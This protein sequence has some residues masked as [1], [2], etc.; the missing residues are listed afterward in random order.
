M[1]CIEVLNGYLKHLPTLKNSPKAV[2]TTTKGNNPFSKAD[3]VVAIILASVPIT[4]QNQYNLMHSM[5]L[6]M[7]RMLLLDLENI[8]RIMLEKYNEKF[9]GQ[10][11]STKARSNGKGKPKNGMSGELAKAHLIEYQRRHGPRSFASA[12]RL[13]AAPTRCRT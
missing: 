1:S 5:V 13:M 11:K 12:A 2:L 9:Q 10:V 8:N 4:W 3:L 6:E 7:P